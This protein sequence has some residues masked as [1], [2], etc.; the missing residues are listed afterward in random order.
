M[1]TSSDRRLLALA[2]VLSAILCGTASAM[3][4]TGIAKHETRIDRIVPATSPGS[5]VKP[6]KPKKCLPR[7]PC[8]RGTPTPLKIR[9]R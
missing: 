5:V 3:P 1:K 7:R 4:G 8:D 9:G 6:A 2:A